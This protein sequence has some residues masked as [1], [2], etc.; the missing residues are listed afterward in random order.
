MIRYARVPVAADQT[1]HGFG[2]IFFCS[3]N[4]G[5]GQRFLE[6]QLDR[7]FFAVHAIHLTDYGHYFLYDRIDRLRPRRV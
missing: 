5:V 2:G 3:V 4:D 6:S 1:F 7:V